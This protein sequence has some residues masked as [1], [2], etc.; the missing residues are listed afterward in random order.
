MSKTAVIRARVD[1]RMKTRVENIFDKLGLSTSEAIN[2]FLKQVCLYK[3]LPFEI[4]LPTKE[5]HDSVEKSRKGIDVIKSDSA[6]EMFDR[7]GI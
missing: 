1:P 5:L 3:G 7:L 4:K 2:L 6:E